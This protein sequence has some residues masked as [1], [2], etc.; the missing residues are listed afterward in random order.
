M[1]KRPVRGIVAKGMSL[2]AIS[3]AMTRSDPGAGQAGRAEGQQAAV[4]QK[5]LPKNNM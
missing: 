2:E 1:R 3:K 5:D 4:G